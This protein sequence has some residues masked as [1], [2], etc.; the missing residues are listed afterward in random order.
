MNGLPEDQVQMDERR[1]YNEYQLRTGIYI[2]GWCGWSNWETICPRDQIEEYCAQLDAQREQI[3]MDRAM[4][5]EYEDQHNN[6]IALR[7]EVESD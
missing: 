2:G 3:E 4:A 7:G 5:A 1:N 6:E